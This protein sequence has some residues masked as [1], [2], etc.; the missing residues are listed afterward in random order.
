MEERELT[1]KE[2]KYILSGLEKGISDDIERVLEIIKVP[3]KINKNV[4][5]YLNKG[6]KLKVPS[7]PFNPS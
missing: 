5:I 6:I 4:L 1:L 7:T 3:K 2:K